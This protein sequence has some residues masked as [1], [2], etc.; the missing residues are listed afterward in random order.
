MEPFQVIS[1]I[2]WNT[3]ITCTTYITYI[4]HTVKLVFRAYKKTNWIFILYFFLN[5][6]MPTKYYPQKKKTP[7]KA[8]EKY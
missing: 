7:K 8:R 1:S 4:T 3:H 2:S 5:I 6:K